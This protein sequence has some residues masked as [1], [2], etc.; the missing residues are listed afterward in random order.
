MINKEK[1]KRII[2][3]ERGIT[4]IALVITIIVLLILAGIS[5][6]TL[7][8]ENGIL[9]Q[10]DNSKTE[11]RG[12]AVE[13][14]KQ[15]WD[16]EKEMAKRTGGT[17]KSLSDLLDELEAQKLLIGTE[18]QDI[19]ETGM[20]TIGSRTIEFE[21]ERALVTMLK[22][23]IE[24]GCEGGESCTDKE[25]HLHIG[26]YV[27]YNAIATGDTIDTKETING[28]EKDKYK[29]ESQSSAN[30]YTALEKQT[31]TVNNYGETVNWI[32][33]GLTEDEKNILITTGS[34]V[35]KEA[36]DPYLYLQGATGYINAEGEL[37]NIS[38]IYGKG[39]YA[40]GARSITVED[41]NKLAKYNPETEEYG[42]N[43]LYQYKN[44]VTVKGDGTG[45]YSWSNATNGYADGT[46]SGNHTSNGF[47]YI[48]NN[49]VKN[50]SPADT[51]TEI[52]L[53]STYYSYNANGKVSEKIYNKF[54][55]TGSKY[56]WLASH[57]VNVDPYFACFYVRHV[58]IGIVRAGD[59]FDSGGYEYPDSYGV[60]PVVTLKS[61]VTKDNIEILAEQ[62][63]PTWQ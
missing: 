28:E 4:L 55:N 36:E 49:E 50:I 11:T 30:G 13:E 9:T 41:V 25:N 18:R 22:K 2:R 26:D 42:K 6:A 63:E 16:A 51:E 52:S 60:R 29:Y 23:A 32:V 56:Y 43:Q 14:A 40:E 19:E 10:A 17:A 37:N 59:L 45:K 46:F 24:D 35:R 12:A 21:N 15:L 39:D 33:L 44:T 8:G 54:F 7:T 58:S 53:E 61:G 5:I 62:T 34:P 48:E 1:S 31:Y 57:A 20:V 38:A 27:E 47:S 3:K